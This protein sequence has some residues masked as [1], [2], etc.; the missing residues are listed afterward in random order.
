VSEQYEIAQL[1]PKEFGGDQRSR[2]LR[3]ERDYRPKATSTR[4]EI[5]KRIDR[6]ENRLTQ[7]FAAP[8]PK[9]RSISQEKR[10]RSANRDKMQD[11]KQNAADHEQLTSYIPDS[12]MSRLQSARDEPRTISKE[13]S[14]SRSRSQSKTKKKRVTHTEQ[15]APA[16]N[17]SYLF[18]NQNF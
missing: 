14:R 15:S 2:N 17:Q 11:L 4:A 8:P 6:L 9:P 7:E 3:L 1:A 12:R 13:R 18:L 5:K 10:K 16:N